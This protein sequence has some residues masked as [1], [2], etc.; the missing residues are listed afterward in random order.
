MSSIKVIENKISSAKKYLKIILRYKKYKKEEIESNI[1]IRGAVERYL[2]LTV[3]ASIDLAEAVIAYKNYRKPTTMS[4]A[5]DILNEERII[6]LKL[7]DKL[8]KMVGFRNII[9]HDYEKIDYQIL[10]NVLQTGRFDIEIFLRKIEEK[11]KLK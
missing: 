3:Q 7:A 2:Y 9:T 6:S 11:L 5:F 10:Y 1:D 4:E 8:V